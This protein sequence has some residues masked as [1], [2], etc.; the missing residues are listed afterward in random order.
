M[1]RNYKDEALWYAEEHGILEYKV[2][3][4]SMIYYANY[5]KYLAEQRRTYKDVEKAFNEFMAKYYN[6][7]PYE[8]PKCAAFK[9]AYKGI[10]SFESL[11]NMCRFHGVVLDGCEDKYDSEARLYHLLDTE[12]KNETWRFHN[13]LVETI[14]Y[15][16]FDLRRSIAEGNAAPNTTSEKAD[17]Y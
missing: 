1:K 13:L 8:T 5:P 2:K 17:R 15:N 11:K 10:G 16:N 4:S 7:L 6:K 12:Y 3:G 9:D 14:K